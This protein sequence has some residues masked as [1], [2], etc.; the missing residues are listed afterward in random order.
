MPET[1]E[2][3]SLPE[4]K[5]YFEGFPL[6]STDLMLGLIREDKADLPALPLCDPDI[7]LNEQSVCFR[8]QF[9]FQIVMADLGAPCRSE[10]EQNENQGC[11]QAQNFAPYPKR[12]QRG[13]F[14]LK[15]HSP[16]L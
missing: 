16:S 7:V 9:D 14:R 4:L 6:T 11:R 2:R 8:L 10:T 13:I 5:E 15:K 1:A 3:V 12:R